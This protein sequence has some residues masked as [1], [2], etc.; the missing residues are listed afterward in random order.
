[1]EPSFING[2]KERPNSTS[3]TVSFSRLGKSRHSVGSC[4]QLTKTNSDRPQLFKSKS[5]MSDLSHLET[6]SNGILNNYSINNKPAKPIIEFPD[7][8]ELWQVQKPKI[9]KPLKTIL[10][11]PLPVQNYQT[12]V[13]GFK[14]ITVS[15]QTE[16]F[17]PDDRARTFSH[18]N[19]ASKKKFLDSINCDASCS[20]SVSSDFDHAYVHK[21]KS[22]YLIEPRRRWSYDYIKREP[23][24]PDP[25]IDSPYLVTESK[26][27]SPKKKCIIEEWESKNTIFNIFTSLAQIVY[28]FFTNIKYLFIFY[29]AIICCILAFSIKVLL[30]FL[31]VFKR[32][33]KFFLIPVRYFFIDSL[34]HYLTKNINERRRFKNL[35]LS[36]NLE[37]EIQDGILN[38]KLNQIFFLKIF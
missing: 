2:T 9:Q 30:Y 37:S 32:V 38:K 26:L 15:R 4:Q 23:E 19:L 13:S 34:L 21:P 6:K 14:N 12:Q 16:I 11:N 3:K 24:I 36:N 10:K 27:L 5:L 31:N 29:L 17:F 25:D 7:E 22:E 20:S 28:V 33:I 1:M 35:Q 18:K 8:T